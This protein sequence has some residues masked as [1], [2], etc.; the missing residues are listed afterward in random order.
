ML[1]LIRVVMAVVLLLGISLYSRMKNTKIKVF[2]PFL[3]YVLV[4][5]VL[6]ILK[7]MR[8]NGS[9]HWWYNIHAP[10]QILFYLFFYY[11][12]IQSAIIKKW[13]L[14][15]SVVFLLFAIL[16]F[17]FLEGWN[18][19]NTSTLRIG[20]LLIVCFCFLYF[21]ELLNSKALLN[22][23]KQPTFWLSTGIMVFHIG[24]FVYLSV[25]HLL[26]VENVKAYGG[27][28]TF[29]PKSLS[30]LLYLFFAIAF[31]FEWKKETSS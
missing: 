17:L 20:F 6:G 14:W 13:V 7:F 3:A 27:L 10:F 15:A 8:I 21:H 24:F 12:T 18:S 2:I 9:N 22:P 30:I 19:F 28:L 23:L 26:T 5:E 29:I 1:I 11:Y 25:F 31:Y 16:N 4:V